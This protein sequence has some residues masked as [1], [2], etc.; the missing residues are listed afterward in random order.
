MYRRPEDAPP[1]SRQRRMTTYETREAR[2]RWVLH[3][4]AVFWRVLM[5]LGMF[6]HKLAL[7]RP[8]KPDFYR[9]IAST[10]SG[11]PGKIRLHFY[12][13]RDYNTQ[14]RLWTNRPELD[15]EEGGVYV[16][17]AVRLQESRES[18]EDSLGKS[19]SRQSR[20]VSIASNVQR[21][22][23]RLSTSARQWGGY[24]VVI[25]FHGGGFTLGSADDDAR[26]CGTVVDECHAVV[27]SVDYRLA[28]EHPFPTAVE[29]GVWS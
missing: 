15:Y 8:P 27:V 10:I 2:P 6:F 24:P 16:D 12:V 17:D 5:R 13:P 1:D 19:Q 3:M 28:P 25:N 20:R 26:W 9:D 22:I 11:V 18:S 23:R 14:R 29:D 4:Q 7:P 21:S